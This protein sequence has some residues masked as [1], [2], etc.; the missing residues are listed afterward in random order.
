MISIFFWNGQQW[1]NGRRAKR[2]SMRRDRTQLSIY[3]IVTKTIPFPCD[4]KVWKVRRHCG[5]QKPE[6]W[7]T[8]VLF[9][10]DCD[11]YYC[12]TFFSCS[13]SRISLNLL[14]KVKISDGA[15]SRLAPAQLPSGREAVISCAGDYGDEEAVLVWSRE[16]NA[17]CVA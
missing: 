7:L 17:V 13:V 10:I 15:V 9:S 2:L 5:T 14:M 3:S 8:G 16:E 6:T 1:L 11:V 4:D 12:H